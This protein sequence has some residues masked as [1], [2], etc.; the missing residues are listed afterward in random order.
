M[1]LDR[2]SAHIFA[3]VAFFP[4]QTPKVAP[5]N[6]PNVPFVGGLKKHINF[7]NINF[8]APTPNTPFLAPPPPQKK[9]YVRHF[10]G[11]DAKK[12]PT[13][14]FPGGFLGSKR[15][16]QKGHFRPQRVWFIDVFLP[17]LG[18]SLN[19]HH[20]PPPPPPPPKKKG[21]HCCFFF[22]VKQ[23]RLWALDRSNSIHPHPYFPWLYVF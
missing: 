5:Q 8:L 9:V 11:K 17:F 16:S 18:L 7:F 15:G 6:V 20:G 10:L 14:F 22:L 4:R 2:S 21:Q 13:N 1:A 3:E 23:A 19:L 12:G